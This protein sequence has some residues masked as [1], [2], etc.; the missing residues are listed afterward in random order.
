M[1]DAPE[2]PRPALPPTLDRMTAA[3]VAHATRAWR[4]GRDAMQLGGGVLV[5]GVAALGATLGGALAASGVA[6]VGAVLT[7]G[8]AALVVRGFRRAR[9][10]RRT[11]REAT[12]AVRD[13]HLVRAAA[14]VDRLVPEADPDAGRTPRDH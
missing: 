8:G 6:A 1:P 13:L 10:A 5:A 4:R 9:G 2:P 14:E 12:D 7:A 3:R 11:I